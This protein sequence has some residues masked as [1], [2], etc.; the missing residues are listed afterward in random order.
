MRVRD[1]IVGLFIGCFM[2][3]CCGINI[4]L[5]INE[6]ARSPPTLRELAPKSSNAAHHG[7]VSPHDVGSCMGLQFK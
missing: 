4:G 1:F 2:G 3:V 6:S 5:K 7:R